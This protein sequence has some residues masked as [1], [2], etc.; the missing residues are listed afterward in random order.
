MAQ[1]DM[2]EVCGQAETSDDAWKSAQKLLPDM[3][4]LDLHLPGL[5]STFD[6]IKRLCSLR[7][8]KVIIFASQGKASEV[9]DLLD[10]GA[11]AYV[12]KEDAPALIRMTMLMV[13]RGSRNV[14]SPSLPRHLTRL[15]HSERNLLRHV[16]ARGGIAK[17]AERLSLTEEQLANELDQLTAKLELEDVDELVKWAKK[18]DF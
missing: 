18:H 3:V 13:S 12:L 1:G 2:I 11:C 10:A 7:N 9:Q 16:T 17:A 14:I 5:I 15:S 6:L 8:A 4:L